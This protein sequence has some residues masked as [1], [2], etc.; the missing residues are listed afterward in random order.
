MSSTPSSGSTSST[1][2]W[3]TASPSTR[4]TLNS[5]DKEDPIDAFL[6]AGYTD[7]LFE[8]QGENAY[9]YVFDGQTTRLSTRRCG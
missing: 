6:A 5:Y 3:S 8:F 7:L 4:R 1:S 9:S 2:V